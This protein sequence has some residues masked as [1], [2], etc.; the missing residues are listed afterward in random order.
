MV[1]SWRDNF[2]H[3]SWALVVTTGVYYCLDFL[4]DRLFV[5]GS[6]TANYK[7]VYIT[8]MLKKPDLHQ[9]N[10]QS[11]RLISNLL[12]VSKLQ[13]RLIA[14]CLFYLTSVGQMPSLQSA[15]CAYHSKE[16][17]VLRV[18]TDSLQALDRGDLAALTL[19]DLSAA[20]NNVDHMVLLRRLEVT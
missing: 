5:S 10:V 20:F 14:S 13:D 4:F 6:I 11:C 2:S 18:L 3:V 8:P 16:T 19:F 1:R 7:A 17:F 12:V 15:Y 9:T